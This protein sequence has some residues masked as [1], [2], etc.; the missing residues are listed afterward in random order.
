MKKIFFLCFGF[1]ILVL[2]SY[3]P[4]LA[5]EEPKAQQAQ[6]QRPMLAAQGWLRLVD[7]GEYRQSWQEA[8]SYFKSMI[9][10]QQWIDQIKGVSKVLGKVKNRTLRDKQKATTLPGA[11]DGEYES[12]SYTTNMENKIAAVE[13]VTVVKDKDNQWRMVGYFIR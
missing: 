12:I 2:S 10:Q 9:T 1:V 7:Q 8:G 3:Q 13:T 6:D 4:T 11:P 5:Q